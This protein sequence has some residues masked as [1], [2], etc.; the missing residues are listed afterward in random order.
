MAQMKKNPVSGKTVK[1]TTYSPLNP[2]KKDVKMVNERTTRKPSAKGSNT[3]PF[4]VKLMTPRELVGGKEPSKIKRAPDS[5]LRKTNEKIKSTPKVKITGSASS[6]PQVSGSMIKSQPKT[7]AKSKPLTG[8]AAVKAI[9]NRTSPAGVKKAE[10][11]AKKAID[12][13]YPGLYKKSK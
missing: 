3:K 1:T 7:T 9:Q 12:K 2:F 10:A 13:K 11:G 4:N 6:K 8:P 5:M